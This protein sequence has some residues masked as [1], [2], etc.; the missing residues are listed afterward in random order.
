MEL[1]E[2]KSV[3]GSKVIPMLKM[4]YLPLH[5]SSNIRREPATQLL[6]NL[7]RSVADPLCGLESA[8][9]MSLATLLYPRFKNLGSLSSSTLKANEVGNRLQAQRAAEVKMP[10][11]TPSAL[12]GSTSE[13]A[14]PEPSTQHFSSPPSSGL[15]CT[16]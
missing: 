7:K 12:V 9:V 5:K 3:S 6:K 16:C 11:L 15:S 4:L 10:E 8:S 2:E 13:E 1:S 14:Q